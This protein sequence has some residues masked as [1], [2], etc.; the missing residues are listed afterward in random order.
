MVRL[1]NRI[2]SVTGNVRY[3]QGVVTEQ[4]VDALRECVAVL[5][6]AGKVV[7]ET[8]QEQFVGDHV[9]G[10]PVVFLFSLGHAVAGGVHHI[11]Q[12]IG[13]ADNSLPRGASQAG[14]MRGRH[15]RQR[16]HPGQ[17]RVGPGEIGFG[18]CVI[19]NGRQITRIASG[20]IEFG[21][22]PIEFVGSFFITVATTTIIVTAG[23]EHIRVCLGGIPR[24]LGGS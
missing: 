10:T 20:D 7:R 14:G 6:R 17:F 4:V 3:R 9:V 19:V 18:D 22:R 13:D 12:C 24:A 11:D 8:D 21:S 16:H 5:L 2:V 1:A 15:N 23:V